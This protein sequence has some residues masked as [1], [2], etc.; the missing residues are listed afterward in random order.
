MPRLLS[1]NNK[2]RRRQTS[3]TVFA[4]TTTTTSFIQS[5]PSIAWSITLWSIWNCNWEA[6]LRENENGNSTTMSDDLSR[7][8][9]PGGRRQSFTEKMFGGAREWFQA[10]RSTSNPGASIQM[11]SSPPN[12]DHASGGSRSRSRSLSN[13]YMFNH[14]RDLIIPGPVFWTTSL[15]LIRW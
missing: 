8:S 2:Q 3:G 7:G 9:T 10:N 12:D 15:S 11:G 1:L 5:L 4:T 14:H 13:S 6:R